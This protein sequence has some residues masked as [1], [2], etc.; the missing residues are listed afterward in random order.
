[1]QQQSNSEWKNEKAKYSDEVYVVTGL[2]YGNTGAKSTRF[3]ILSLSLEQ[4][5][6]RL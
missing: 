2:V 3:F 1:M 4:V 5:K 6:E